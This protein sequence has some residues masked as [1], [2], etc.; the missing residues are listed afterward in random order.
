M[1]TLII[2]LLAA[3]GLVNSTDIHN[4]KEMNVP[5]IPSMIY[6]GEYVPI[7]VAFNATWYKNNPPKPVVKKVHRKKK[8]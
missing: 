6:L 1:K 8:K 3:T 2:G 7:Q 5:E 4:P